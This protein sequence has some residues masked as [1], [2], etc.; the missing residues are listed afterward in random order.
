MNYYLKQLLFQVEREI[1]IMKLVEHPHV[2]HL[3]DV[4]E[5]KKYLLVAKFYFCG[6]NTEIIEKTSTETRKMLTRNYKNKHSFSHY[7]Q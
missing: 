6:K 4:Y 1:A 5:N 2:L 3:Y 7:D